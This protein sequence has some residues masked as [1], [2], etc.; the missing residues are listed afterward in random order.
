MSRPRTTRTPLFALIIGINSYQSTEFRPLR[1]AVP[2]ALSFKAYLETRVNVPSE[3]ISVLLDKAASRLAIIE[4]FIHLKD[5]RRIKKGDAIFIYF[6]GHGG[7]IL[8]PPSWE[9]GGPGTKIQVII[10]YDCDALER[11]RRIP[12]IPD[13]TIG[14]LL[15]RIAEKKGD[16]I[17]VVFDCCHAAS[18][19]R[20]GDDDMITRSVELDSR[21]Y[22]ETLDQDIWDFG[23]RGSYVPSKFHHGGLGSHVLL[24]ACGITEKANEYMGHGQF[25]VAL[26]KL[27][28]NVS[29]NK[30]RY[31]DILAHLDAIPGQNPQCEGATLN[32]A[33]FDAK[34]LPPER[35]AFDVRIEKIGGRDQYVINGGMIHGIN[36][37]SEFAVYR[38]A[39]FNFST[40]IGVL[41]ANALRPFSATANVPAGTR[42]FSLTPP[43][44]AIQTKVGRREDLRL[45]IAPNDAF[46]P[47]FR[48][49]LEKDPI[50]QNISLVRE[51]NHGHVQISLQRS[52][53]T[54]KITDENV[55]RYGFTR[56]VK[57]IDA[58]LRNL[59][60]VLKGIA[61]YY[62]ELNRGNSDPEITGRIDV[63]LYRLEETLAV[64]DNSGLQ[65]MVLTP[66]GP[67]LCRNGM[68]D[69]VVEED[70]PYGI[71]LT[72]KT[73]HDLYPNLFHFNNSDLSIAAYAQTRADGHFVD[74]PL[75]KCGGTF[76]IGYG[77][78]DMSP[79]R[80]SCKRDRISTSNSSRYIC[81]PSLLIS[82]TYRSSHLLLR[83]AR[84]R[85]GT[86]RRKKPG[87]LSLSQLF[88]VE[89]LSPGRA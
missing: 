74:V 38:K 16:N 17:T 73:W 50:F 33:L 65:G 7:E 11:A 22:P 88:S 13:R 10:P 31:S 36:T 32:R 43:A 41:I 20:G 4:E 30:L 12:P 26:L 62:G 14:A 27:F 45:H 71:K 55:T 66:T 87:I 47:R 21:P 23:P 58:D 63:E 42:N 81:P 51:P 8:P 84:S 19:T 83:I 77:S 2:D 64:L 9:C 6:A 48:T 67:N 86:Q 46:F 18:G 37:G 28:S 61:H 85:R 89:P 44:I 3:Q 1:G 24:A 35:T 76:A 60:W 57:D 70:T 75:R 80:S 52:K 79:S 56:Q 49:L 15:A 29:L 53:I 69:L 25:S 72:N 82:P 78:G 5:D 68:V 40:Q 39:D 54:L 59:S 34:V